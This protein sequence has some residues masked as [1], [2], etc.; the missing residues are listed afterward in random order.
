MPYRRSFLLLFALPLLWGCEKEVPDFNEPEQS[1]LSITERNERD[2]AEIQDLRARVDSII[3]FKAQ[4]DR[5]REGKELNKTMDAAQA[6]RLV[7]T[8]INF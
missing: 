6:A 8:G 4:V 2:S 7:E 5:W 3:A 1:Y